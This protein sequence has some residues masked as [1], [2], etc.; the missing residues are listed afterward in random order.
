MTSMEMKREETEEAREDETKAV[1]GL[2]KTRGRSLEVTGLGIIASL[3]VAF[4]SLVSDGTVP[5]SQYL[6]FL[7]FMLVSATGLVW[8]M[9]KLAPGGKLKSDARVRAGAYRVSFGG[10]ASR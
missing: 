5:F 9:L 4:G 2:L 6:V 10:R 7:A 3:I 1:G 8:R